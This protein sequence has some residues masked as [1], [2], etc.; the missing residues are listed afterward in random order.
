MSWISHR[1]WIAPMVNIASLRK[2]KVS[3]WFPE[4]CATARDR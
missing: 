4:I 2:C 1:R 3:P